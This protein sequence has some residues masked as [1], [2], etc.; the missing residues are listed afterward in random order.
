MRVLITGGVGFIGVNAA[1]RFLERKDDLVIFD[2]L[3][4]AGVMHNVH[5]LERSGRF[6]LVQEDIR[7]AI[8]LQECLH[9]RG[10]FDLVLHLAAQVAVTRSVANPREDYEI[11]ALGTFNLLEA[12]RKTN[13]NGLLIYAST[14]KVYGRMDDIGIKEEQTRHAYAELI[15]GVSET[16]SLDFH[17]PY[18]CSKG[19]ADQY[20]RDYSRIYGVP[21]VVF[22]QSCIYGP[23]QYGVEDQGWLAWFAIAAITGRPI[24]IYGDGKQVRDALFVE[25]LI[26]AFVQ[27]SSRT[28]EVAGKIYNIGGG[29]TRTVSLIELVSMLEHKLATRIS[30]LRDRERPGDQKVFVSDIRLAAKDL[31]WRPKTDLESG[32]Q[33]LVA[34]ITAY[35]D[36]F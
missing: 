19:A 31:C 1:K 16:A 7:N 32:M 25:D 26:D 18:G 12:L 10:P 5:D 13:F 21:S 3:S 17:S 14:N 29:P 4:R 36:R 15:H 6:E 33:N 35:K 8:A 20:V 30:L 11:N 9:S 28:T 34:W 23:H 27:A 24:T 22:R 2:N